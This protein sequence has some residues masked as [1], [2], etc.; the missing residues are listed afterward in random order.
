MDPVRVPPVPTPPSRMSILP[1]VWYQISG[2]VVSLREVRRTSCEKLEKRK[3]RQ[4]HKTWA[5]KQKSLAAEL[6]SNEKQK[7]LV[8]YNKYLW[9]LGLSLLLNCCR[10]NPPGVLAAICSALAIAPFM[11]ADS[12]IGYQKKGRQNTVVIKSWQLQSLLT[13]VTCALQHIL[14]W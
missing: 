10:I 1:D 6:C 7:M 4:T 12:T 8:G 3:D 14:Q 13:R 11:P 5:R 2:P 9:A